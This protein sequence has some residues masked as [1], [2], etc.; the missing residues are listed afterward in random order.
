MEE[1]RNGIPTRLLGSTGARVTLIGVGGYHQGKV[2]AELGQRIVRTAIDEGINFLDNAWCYHDGESERIMGLALQG[3]YRDK[4]FLMT[5]NH[6]RDGATY[7]KQLEESLTRLKVDMIDLV[8]FHDIGPGDAARIFSEGA[9]EAALEAREQGKIR[10]IGFTGHTWP[11]LHAEM[12]ERAKALGEGFAWDTVQLPINLLDAQY[13]SFM[14]AIVPP[15]RERGM[16]V[17]GMKSLAGGEL[18]KTGVTPQDAIAFALS[19]PIDTLVTGIDSLEVLQQNLD[20]ARAWQPLSERDE[21]RLLE[22][23]AE[24][25]SRGHLETYKRV[26]QGS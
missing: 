1:R 7:R 23:V 17:I 14:Q 16:G 25:A 24:P 22:A 8:Q 12:L 3:G 5:K 26:P 20:I 10:F 11:S 9:I 4:V 15:A 13:H 21:R 6:G 19:Q 2:G 18:L